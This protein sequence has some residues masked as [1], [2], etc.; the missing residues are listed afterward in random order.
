[1]SRT[2]RSAALLAAAALTLGACSSPPEAVVH[3]GEVRAAAVGSLTAQDVAA[4]QR[5]FGTDLLAAVCAAG[6]GENLVLSPTS[7]AEALGLLYPAAD[8]ETAEALGALLHLP[9]WS[10]DVV[11][12]M[13]ERTTALAAL[14]TDDRP[15]DDGPDSL[16]SSNH[17]WTTAAVAPTTT[18]LDD[19]ATAFDAQVEELDF[20]TDPE[21]STER[22]NASVREDTAGLIEKLYETPLDGSTVAVL[23][24]ALHLQARW[25][26]PFGETDDAPFTTPTGPTTV[27]MMHGSS[28][29]ARTAGGWTSVE[30][31]YLDGTLVAHV[32]LPPEGTDPCSVTAED[33]DALAAA[34]PA[35]VDLSMPRLHLEQEHRLLPVLQSMG[36]PTAGDFP[37]LGA[38]GF[39]ITDVIQKTYLDV[40]EEGTVAA[41]ATGVGLAGGAPEERQHVLVDRPYLLLL[42]DTATGSPLFTAVVQ[43]PSQ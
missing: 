3:R 27:A 20:A 21:G 43:D 42:S 22:I 26:R 13:R 38:G 5:A 29:D 9:P 11:A 33:L 12:A 25:L 39:A 2:I 31:P 16:R 18:Y 14:R 36:L 32:V 8:G 30:L 40:D 15:R 23:T 34:A 4:A 17:L 10:D 6:L 35:E 24:N 1:M 37:G 7:A 41:A 28:G 19:I